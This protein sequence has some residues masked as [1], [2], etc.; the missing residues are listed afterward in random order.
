LIRILSPPGSHITLVISKVNGILK[1][2][3]CH[4]QWVTKTQWFRPNWLYS[5]LSNAG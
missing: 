5:T 1:F 2:G 3:W 4:Y